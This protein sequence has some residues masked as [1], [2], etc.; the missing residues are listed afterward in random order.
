VQ[1]QEFYFFYSTKQQQIIV[2]L[3]Q[4]TPKKSWRGKKC[5]I[6]F[7]NGVKRGRKEGNFVCVASRMMVNAKPMFLLTNETEVEKEQENEKNN[8]MHIPK[9]LTLKVGQLQKT[10]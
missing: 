7:K 1:L 8:T 9:L 10:K 3:Q 5:S 4:Q 2:A 6:Q